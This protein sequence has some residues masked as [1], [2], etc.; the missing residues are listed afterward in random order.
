MWGETLFSIE[1]DDYGTYQEDINAPE[2]IEVVQGS[3]MKF[4]RF[5]DYYDNWVKRIGFSKKKMPEF[6]IN[7]VRKILDLQIA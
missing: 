2:E 1:E 4:K 7:R 5:K 6:Q 3:E